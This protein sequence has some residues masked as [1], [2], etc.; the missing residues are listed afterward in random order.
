L[1]VDSAHGLYV[2][3]QY[4]HRVLNLPVGS[5]TPA[6]L[7]FTGL[8]EPHDVAVDN[9]GNVYV[10]DYKNNRVLKLRAGSDTP[11]ELPFTGLNFPNGVARIATAVSTSA[12]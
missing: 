10:V 12:T 2:V 7:P 11:D 9:S 5:D 4:N 8:R 1:A 3:D 6:E